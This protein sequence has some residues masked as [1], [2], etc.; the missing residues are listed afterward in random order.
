MKNAH[1]LYM[2]LG[3]IISFIL[4]SCADYGY[5]SSSSS[6]GTTHYPSSSLSVLPHGYT[7]VYVGSTPYWRNNNHWYCYDRGRY[8][9]CARPSGYRLGIP[10]SRRSY[11]P[12]YVPHTQ[13]YPRY[14]RTCP[15]YYRSR[16]TVS[17]SYSSY[18]PSNCSLKYRRNTS[19]SRGSYSN[20]SYPQHHSRCNSSRS[21]SKDKSFRSS[22]S[23]RS[24]QQSHTTINSPSPTRKMHHNLPIP[25]Q[26]RNKKTKP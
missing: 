19:Y 11:S 2:T 24:K 1:L 21:H 12:P 15:T 23:R 17:Y 16:P 26:S 3:G 20:S 13:P 4:P 18:R 5:Y 10:H 25:R 9:S 7:R 6:Y 8:R 22:S 14:T